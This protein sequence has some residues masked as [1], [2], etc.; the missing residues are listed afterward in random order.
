VLAE[1]VPVASLCPGPHLALVL[2]G[3]QLCAL[4]DHLGRS[5]L[6]VAAPARPRATAMGL[7]CRALRPRR[8]G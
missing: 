6:A 7:D 8:V 2:D 4:T 3:A 1:G 5:A